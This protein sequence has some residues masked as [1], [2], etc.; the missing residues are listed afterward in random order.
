[1][2]DWGCGCG[3]VLRHYAPLFDSVAFTGTDID[4]A[5]IEWDRANITGVRFELN[6]AHPPLPCGDEAFDLVYGASVFT[7]LDEELQ[8]EW[9]GELQR[10]T[11]PGGL[12]L[13]STHGVSVYEAHCHTFPAASACFVRSDR[14]RLRP[15]HRRRRPSRLV[16]DQ[17]ADTLSTSSVRSRPTSRSCS[18]SIA[19]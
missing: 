11:K 1:M 5:M 10:V 19:A 15:Q 6:G 14:L 18:T 8:A 13:L 4:E 2:L 3:R 17:H 7:H 12:V 9:L 16:P